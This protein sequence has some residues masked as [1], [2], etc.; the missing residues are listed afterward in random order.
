MGQHQPRTEGRALRRNHSQCIR[1][2]PGHLPV[3]AVGDYF[4]WGPNLAGVVLSMV[5]IVMKLTIP[6][7]QNTK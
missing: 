7:R 3:Q 6:S 5:Q 4:I 1:R 2:A